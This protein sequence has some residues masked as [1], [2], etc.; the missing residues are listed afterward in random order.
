MPGPV[1]TQV[2]ARTVERVPG[3]RRIPLLRLLALG[4]VVLLVRDH[5]AKLEPQERRRIAELVRRGRG[6]KSRLSESER[7]ELEALIAKAEPR[8]LVGTVAEKLAP[9]PLPS[10]IVRGPK[11]R[12]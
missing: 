2:I 4:E 1:I 6:R 7:E 11:R 5:M 9:F 10:R 12:S 3:L 8:L